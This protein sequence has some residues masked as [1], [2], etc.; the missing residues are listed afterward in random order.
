MK[1]SKNKLIVIL[2]LIANIAMSQDTDVPSNLKDFEGIWQFIP[3]EGSNDTTFTL[4]DIFKK[5]RI[6]KIFE[7]HDS[8]NVLVAMRLI[9]FSP[10]NKN[11]VKLSDLEE[12][13]QR[14]YFYRPNPQA[15]NDSI[16][17]FDQASPSCFA[18]F[19]GLGT[20]NYEPP[21]NGKPNYF[22][23]N[24]DGREYEY[25]RQIKHIPNYIVGA[26]LEN[27]KELYKVETFLGVKYAK[28]KIDKSFIFSLPTKRTNIYILKDDPVQVLETKDD[29]LK[30]R[31]Y[32]N[33]EENGKTI[34]GWIKKTDVE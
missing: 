16:K 12:T 18:S 4:I 21:S 33:S 24:F 3:S 22:L 34:E 25:Y 29:W 2:L 27:K 19:N 20:D 8:K 14:M 32:G 15:P 26:L 1:Y 9:G 10:K 28:I 13:G 11:I 7:W 5:G 30:I 31:Y 6:L 17:Y 23:F